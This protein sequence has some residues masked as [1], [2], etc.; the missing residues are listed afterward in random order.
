MAMTDQHECSLQ[1]AVGAHER[2]PG[3]SC[4]YWSEDRCQVEEL[5]RADVETN[6]ELAAFLLDLRA[7]IMVGEAWRPFRRVAIPPPHAR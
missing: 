5:L 7:H 6:P 3:E 4:P 2:C 1:H